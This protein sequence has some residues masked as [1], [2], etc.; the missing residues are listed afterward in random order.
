MTL[1]CPKCGSKRIIFLSTT[2][3]TA[4]G[5]TD[6][7]YLCK[8]CDYRG[9]LILDTIIPKKEPQSFALAKNLI[10]LDLALFAIVI[11]LLFA[12]MITGLVGL[13]ALLLWVAVFLATVVYFTIHLTQGSD[14]WY[15]VGMM[16]TSGALIALIVGILLGLDIY[17]MLLL[18]TFSALGMFLLKWMFTDASE[19]EI[20]RDL[21]KLSKEIK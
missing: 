13:V 8:D 3:G 15:Q 21:K 18:V 11:I 5:S 4:V 6:Q 9:S 19:D 20:V 12:G 2:D 7:R 10:F 16:L 14:E 17:A 1:R